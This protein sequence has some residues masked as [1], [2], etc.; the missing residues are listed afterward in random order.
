M[1]AKYWTLRNASEWG[2]TRGGWGVDPNTRWT[3]CQG[4]MNHK[5]GQFLTSQMYVQACRWQHCEVQSVKSSRHIESSKNCDLTRIN[6]VHD[7]VSQ[8]EQ[9]CF[10][11]MQLSICRLKGW[12][13]WEHWKGEEGVERSNIL[14]IK[15]E[16]SLKFE[17]SDLESP[18]FF[19]RGVMRACMNAVG[20]EPWSIPLDLIPTTSRLLQVDTQ[21]SP[22]LSYT[23]PNHDG[24]AATP[25]NISHTLDSQKTVQILNCTFCVCDVGV[26]DG[27]QMLMIKVKSSIWYPASIRLFEGRFW[28]LI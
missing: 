26:T 4:W 20:K 17:G 6:G 14:P 1:R 10:C 24:F 23:C 12:K 2:V 27:L 18:G 5:C 15:L 25:D 13:S 9:S 21:S 11:R 19:R 22:L 28:K 16:I 3:I 7:I 8:F